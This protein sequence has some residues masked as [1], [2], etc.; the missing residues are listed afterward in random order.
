M[1]TYIQLNES[2]LQ[3]PLVLLGLQIVVSLVVLIIWA[4]RLARRG[5]VL[6]E[7]NDTTTNDDQQSTSNRDDHANNSVEL[8]KLA[9]D[10]HK[11]KLDYDLAE[12]EKAK[13]ELNQ[14]EGN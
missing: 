9:K 5:K 3:W 7:T 12:T 10:Y 13:Q 14:L 1:Q 4:V 2:P 11:A 8:L 6:A